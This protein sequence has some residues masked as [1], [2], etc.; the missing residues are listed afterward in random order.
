[1]IIGIEFMQHLFEILDCQRNVLIRD[2]MLNSY[3]F[4][5]RGADV[6]RLL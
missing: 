6:L 1:M 3:M 4:G 5:M 2:L